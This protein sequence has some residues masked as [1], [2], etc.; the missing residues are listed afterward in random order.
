MFYT[1][2]DAL[3]CHIRG[4]CGTGMSFMMWYGGLVAQS[5][6][7]IKSEFADESLLRWTP[8]ITLVHVAMILMVCLILSAR[9]TLSKGTKSRWKYL[10]QIMSDS[11]CYSLRRISRDFSR[12]DACIAFSSPN[13]S[14]SSDSD[15]GA[16]SR[17][18][19]AEQKFNM[20]GKKN[21]SRGGI[22]FF[23]LHSQITE[24]QGDKL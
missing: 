3:F 24:F 8:K 6:T 21:N 18:S 12:A 4:C 1:D 2:T 9:V 13:E 22:V 7:N 17:H 15:I 23:L 11:L 5:W 10:R 19:S 14:R 20:R 16:S